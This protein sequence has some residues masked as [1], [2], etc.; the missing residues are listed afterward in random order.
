MKVKYYTNTNSAGVTHYM[1][2]HLITGDA[3]VQVNSE[4]GV[5]HLGDSEAF[6][7]GS[8]I[9]D[10]YYPASLFAST[11]TSYFRGCNMFS[12]VD[13][14]KRGGESLPNFL[15]MADDPRCPLPV[16]KDGPVW[17]THVNTLDTWYPKACQTRKE[18]ISIRMKNLVQFNTNPCSG[19]NLT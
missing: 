3:F 13:M 15:R 4:T 7:R 1:V 17:A 2:K 5:S 9:K 11:V 8:K 16:I 6:W 10:T 14:A 12:K 19:S 18:G